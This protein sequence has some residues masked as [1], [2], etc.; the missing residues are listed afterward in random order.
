M[1]GSGG[2]G[3]GSGSGGLGFSCAGALGFTV[4]Y[5]ACN[6]ILWGRNRGRTS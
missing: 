2:L 6:Y 3:S 4:G 1:R 5:R